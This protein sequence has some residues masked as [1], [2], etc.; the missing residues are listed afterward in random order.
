LTE[1]IVQ[2]TTK[3]SDIVTRGLVLLALMVMLAVVGYAVFFHRP[4]AKPTSV[5]VNADEPASAPGWN[6]RYQAVC[7]QADR[8][9]NQVRWDV[10]RELLDEHQQFR[11]FQVQLKDG[12]VVVEES[13]AHKIMLRGLKDLATWHSKQDRSKTTP[14]AELLEVYATVDKLTESKIPE[15]KNQALQTRAT[16]FR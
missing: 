5:L 3:K 14:G 13:N 16:F 9:S 11:N 4:T 6:I 7:T 2:E 8:G 12:R 1:D 10:Y 15:L